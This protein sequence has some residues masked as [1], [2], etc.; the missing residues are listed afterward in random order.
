MTGGDPTPLRKML[1]DLCRS[2]G[3][4]KPPANAEKVTRGSAWDWPREEDRD[5]SKPSFRW[6]LSDGTVYFIGYPP[7]SHS[8]V[9]K[10]SGPLDHGAR[11]EAAKKY[12]PRECFE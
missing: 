6:R 12:L 5:P 1:I 8:M 2:K 11:D 4:P 3:F 9:N 7:T 10:V